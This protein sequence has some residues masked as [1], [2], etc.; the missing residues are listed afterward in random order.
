MPKISSIF[1]RNIWTKNK[2]ALQLQPFQSLEYQWSEGHKQTSSDPS[3]VTRPNASDK[4]LTDAT[5]MITTTR[6]A[7]MLKTTM[8][9]THAKEPISN[10]ALKIRDDDIQSSQSLLVG[11]LAD[12]AKY[13]RVGCP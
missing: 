11:Y 12:C 10:S 5:S 1:K 8:Y 13:G 7:A 9:N 2:V 6:A 4:F 3:R